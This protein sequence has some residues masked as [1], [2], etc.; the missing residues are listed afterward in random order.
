V[1]PQPKLQC[2]P[3]SSGSGDPPLWINDIKLKQTLVRICKRMLWT[4]AA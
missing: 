2:Q 4:V 3:A 1:K